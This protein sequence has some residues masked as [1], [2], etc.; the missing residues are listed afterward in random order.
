MTLLELTEPLFQYICRL[1]RVARSGAPAD[2]TVV[3]AELKA[4][5]EDLVQKSASEGRLVT[6][7]KRMELPL[8]FFVDSMIAESTLKFAGQWHGNRLAFEREER[9]GDEKFFELLDETM[10]DNS[11]EASER[12]A[13]YYICV[14]LGFSGM[15]V[16]QPEFL[17]KTMMTIAPRIRHLVDSDQASRVCG[18]A[19]EKVDTRD[20]V[21]P[22]SRKMF[23]IAMIFLIC[24]VSVMVAYIWMFKS[25]T[26][27][28]NTA[29]QKIEQQ[30]Q[31]RVTR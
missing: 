23:V 17:R 7:M 11:E 25:A 18:E 13:V 26:G 9:A 10:R 15:Y 16:G 28:L 31:A 24:A 12:L 29:L 30:D 5:L 4:L 21:E 19:Y 22:P 2:Y 14:G 6:Q 20:L 3:R 8:M 1:N 27:E